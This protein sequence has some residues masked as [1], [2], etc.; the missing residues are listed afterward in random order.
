ME[1]FERHIPTINERT[2]PEIFNILK[3]YIENTLKIDVPKMVSQLKSLR[4]A[5]VMD[6]TYE[7]WLQ[8]AQPREIDY[9][10]NEYAKNFAI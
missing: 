1:K 5:Q 7:E 2:N 10:I 8:S 3:N 9:A 6:Y 4:N